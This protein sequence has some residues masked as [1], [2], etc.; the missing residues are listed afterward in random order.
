MIT[1][2]PLFHA[3]LLTALLIYLPFLAKQAMIHHWV[4]YMCF[5]SIFSNIYVFQLCEKA[6]D[7]QYMQFLIV[8]RSTNNS[9]IGSISVLNLIQ[10]EMRV[11]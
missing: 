5:H 9:S 7:L 4:K 1:T 3:G 6:G 11:H 2:P 10:R 8:G